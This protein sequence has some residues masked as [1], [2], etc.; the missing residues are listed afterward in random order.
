MDSDSR[1]VTLRDCAWLLVACIVVLWLGLGTTRLWDQDEGYYASVA[2]EMFDRQDWVVPTF[3]SE[4]FAHKPPMMFWGMLVGFHFF[5][6]GEF[7]ARWASAFFGTGMILLTY[8]LGR[9]LIDRKAGLIAAVVLVSSL[10]FTVVS[11]S[12][13]ADVHLGFFI[14]LAITLWVHDAKKSL[15]GEH[16]PPID[17]PVT[18][19]RTWIA[20]YFSISLAVLS[21]GPIGFAFPIAILGTLT[22]A[23]PWISGQS[24]SW[25]QC[26]SPKRF[27]QA[28][29]SMRP[30]AGAV[31]L[32]FV[33]APWFLMVNT[34]TEGAF[35]QEFFGVQHIE[36]FSKP[37]DNHSG[38]VYYYLL[39]TLI[40][41]FPWTSFAIPIA[42]HTW[43]QTRQ[44]SNRLAW[45]VV[46]VWLF[47][48][49]VVFSLAS[50][51]L[52]NYI[53]PAYPAVALAIASYF[54]GWFGFQTTES[55]PMG[56]LWRQAGWAF[57]IFS[58]V[59]VG[60]ITLTL[61]TRFGQ[62]WL[63]ELQ[64]DP[65]LIPCLVNFSW[66]GVLLLTCGILGLVLHKLHRSESGIYVMGGL[67]V[68]WVSLLWQLI[69]PSIDRFQTPQKIA[70][71]FIAPSGTAAVGRE[72]AIVGMFRPSMVFYAKQ[73]L[74]FCQDDQGLEKV[75]SEKSPSLV[76]INQSSKEAQRL[77]DEHGYRLSESLD[78][79]PKR[80]SISV[81]RR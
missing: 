74:D 79:F 66:L 17:F 42:L 64:I 61:A 80:G 65:K 45:P 6:V 27:F 21:K 32:M 56:S 16:H 69:I 15:Q 41:F 48:Y 20:I 76:V 35:F 28:T 58:G 1:S 9:L 5:G 11:R 8:F 63:D 62:P 44:S 36:R 71:E 18:R 23:W 52:P 4:L 47:F 3:N 73:S 59:L 53:I 14:L 29:L 72:P 38:P 39:A 78:S 43:N 37:M 55:V 54:S 49:F 13:T 7:A 22:L 26:L 81:Y 67:G 70:S 33:A 31:V 19:L 12:A 40:G 24:T 57:M 68:A 2:R 25:I 77:L 60:G 51:K 34:R 50:T 30:F 75:L 10:M 46:L